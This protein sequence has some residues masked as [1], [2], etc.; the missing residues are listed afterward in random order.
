MSVW[1]RIAKTIGSLA[2]KLDPDNWL[3]GGKDAA[4][5]L[6]LVALS[7]KMAMADGVVS[8]SE[9][10]AFRDIVSIDE[11]DLEQV[12][13]FFLLAQQDVAG[14][15]SYAR[16]IRKLFQDSPQTL[17]HVLDA[18]FNIAAAD[19]MIHEGEFEY[20]KNVSD[21][22][23]FDDARFEQIAARFIVNGNGVDP[24]LVLG[25]VPEAT[26][27]EIKRVYRRLISEHHPDRLIAKGV[28][29]E[30]ISIATARVA[31]IN[32]AYEEIAKARGI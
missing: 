19:G 15:R 27:G 8:V 11:R 14:Y 24:Y 13:R 16:K 32:V 10:A 29:E 22:F 2:N 18:L 23:G 12:E 21:I 4:F 20:L 17:E 3:P 30:L 31:A 26:N 9:V 1:Q 6:A 28:P 7:A 5:T 25:L